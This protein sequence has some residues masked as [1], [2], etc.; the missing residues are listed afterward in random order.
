M[1]DRPRILILEGP[2]GGGK[3]TLASDLAEIGYAVRH[4]GPPKAGEVPYLSYTGA[5]AS[6]FMFNKAGIDPRP[7]VFDRLHLG[8]RV[9]GPVVRDRDTLGPVLHR[10]ID[11]IL[12]GIGGLVVYCATEYEVMEKTW[13]ERASQGKELI[14][15]TSRYTALFNRYE[16]LIANSPV[17]VRYNYLD[18]EQQVDFV[19]SIPLPWPN[20]GPGI[21]A[22]RPGHSTLVVG[23]RIAESHHGVDWPF[24]GFSG[25]S[26][27]LTQQLMFADAREEDLYWVN[28]FQPNTEPTD[29]AF[30]ER[31]NPKRIVALGSIA[32]KWLEDAGH[33][34]IE[35]PHPQY[36]K[37]F[38]A[39]EEYP[40]LEVLRADS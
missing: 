36:W 24:T 40:L 34:P 8:E 17:T 5:L 2:D 1:F 9:Y 31:L 21:G 10:Q 16:E 33:K 7:F 11:R 25:V 32:R 35:V 30:I 26:T 13:R 20:R 28:A 38:R 37:R 23:E 14:T 39:M 18:P 22:W 6:A 27:W 19:Q 4:T 3:T 15:D 29:P 12:L